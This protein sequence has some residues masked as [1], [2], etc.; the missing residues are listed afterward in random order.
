MQNQVQLIVDLFVEIG[1]SIADTNQHVFISFDFLGRHL[2]SE[3]VKHAV[4]IISL[5]VIRCL[6][7]DFV[8][9][10]RFDDFIEHRCLGGD[11]WGIN[12][13]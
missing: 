6:S 5:C 1:D 3:H 11:I 13:G 12:C 9:N 10:H 8:R 4:S 2:A 7:L